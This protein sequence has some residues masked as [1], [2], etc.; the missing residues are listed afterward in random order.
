MS[1]S[2]RYLISKQKNL[3]QGWKSLSKAE[4]G[5]FARLLQILAATAAL[6]LFLYYIGIGGLAQI[7][8]FW[9]IF[10]GKTGG[11][12]G[13]TI[14]PPPPTFSPLPPYTKLAKI[15][16]SG[17]AEPAS[18]ITIFTNGVESGKTIT[19]AGGTFSFSNAQLIDGRN[20]ITATATDQSGNVSQKSA[21]LIITLD[22]KPPDLIVTKPTNGQKFVG[23]QKQI[24]V[25]GKTEAGATVR[26]NDLQATMF[27]DG[28]F[29]A[30]LLASAPGDIKIAVIATDK[31]GNERK[32]ELTVNYAAP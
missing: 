16:L 31:A 4:K 15:N 6:L 20:V 11:T 7:A 17:Y 14:A 26:V 10:T 1:I 27:A 12:Q 21:E 19:E 5:E 28:S 23:E 30:T 3:H 2:K 9:T 22:Q 8:G 25:E 32:A 29:K 18:K 13:D 24:D